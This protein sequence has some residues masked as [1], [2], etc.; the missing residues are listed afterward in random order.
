[1]L[2]CFASVIA[3]SLKEGDMTRLDKLF[4]RGVGRVKQILQVEKMTIDSFEFTEEPD[5]E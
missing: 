3:H 5:E 1:M 2:A 4:D